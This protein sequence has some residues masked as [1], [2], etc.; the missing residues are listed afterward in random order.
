M[1]DNSPEALSSRL[2][3]LA[4]NGLSRRGFLARTGAVIMGGVLG[5]AVT[6]FA[7]PEFAGAGALNNQCCN[8][9]NPTCDFKQM[10]LTILC[11][12]HPYV[13]ANSCPSGSQFY[14]AGSWCVCPDTRGTY[15]KCGSGSFGNGKQEILF[16]DCGDTACSGS[17]AQCVHFSS[18]DPLGNNDSCCGQ[19]QWVNPSDSYAVVCRV[20]SCVANTQ[21]TVGG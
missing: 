12:Y 2:S 16:A 6:D 7:F 18:S 10:G 15:D 1:R 9:N 14:N 8:Q 3:A 21:C 4:G 13:N 19:T 20:W 17:G 11:S 5:S